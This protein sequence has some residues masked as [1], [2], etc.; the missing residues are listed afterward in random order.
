MNSLKYLIKKDNKEKN[1][2]LRVHIKHHGFLNKNKMIYYI[3]EDNKN[4]GFFAMYRYWLEYLYFADIC[5]YIPVINVGPEFAYGETEK[6]HG[7]NNPFEYYFIPPSSI[8][9]QDAKRSYNII[10]ADINHRQMVELIF[11]GK[12]CH[13]K[14]TRRYMYEMGRIVKKYIHF[15]QNT[16]KYIVDGINSLDINK[17]KVLGIHIRGTDFRSNYDNHPIYISESEWFEKIDLLFRQNSY[18]KMFIATDDTRILKNFIDKYGNKICYYK[19]VQRSNKNQSVAFSTGTRKNHKYLL[20]L[21]VIR[22]MYTLSMC[23]GLIAGISQVA[24]CAQINKLSRGEKY[25]D[26]KIINKGLNKNTHVF[27]RH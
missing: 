19:D 7:T 26:I 4:L 16:E 2:L 10:D 23:P 25:E 11:T 8:N 21:E 3:T 1:D 15:N 18:T 5:G 22:D 12:Y 27:M 17:E 13:Y 14:V 9:V 6:I 24:I 20:G